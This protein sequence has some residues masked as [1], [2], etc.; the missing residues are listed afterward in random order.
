MPAPTSISHVVV[1]ATYPVNGDYGTIQ[2]AINDGQTAI[3]VR[4]GTYLLTESITIPADTTITGEN[5]G[6]VII[7]CDGS[8]TL[9]YSGDLYNVIV[10]G[11]NVIVENITVTDCE[12]ALGAFHFN[13][14]NNSIVRNCNVEFSTRAA[15][16][17]GSS[18]CNFESCKVNDMTL[19]SVFVDQN[20]SDNRITNCSIRDGESYGVVLEGSHN[21]I[22]HCTIVAHINNDGILILSPF[23]T[24][25]DNT[26]NNNENGIYVALD[27][28]DDN[29]IMGNT[30][31]ENEGYGININ[32]TSQTTGNVVIGNVCK[33]NTVADIRFTPNNV[34]LGNSAVTV[35]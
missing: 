22:L 7:D 26:V 23:N 32:S 14:A 21:K 34:A 9:A 25:M 17:T 3:F 27:G 19:Q 1:D 8:A 33:G 13:S 11:D 10:N 20:S 31:N 24:I 6:G 12:N 2:D 16:F 29:T 15:Y 18:F 28:G 30:C 35:V 4:N 5:P